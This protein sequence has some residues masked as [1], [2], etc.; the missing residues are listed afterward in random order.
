VIRKDSNLTVLLTNH[1]TPGHSIET[2]HIEV[3]LDNA[4]EPLDI[5]IQRI[6]SVHANPKAVW[7]DMGQPEYLTEQDVEQL[8][9]ASSLVKERQSFSNKDGAVVLELDLPRDAV[10]AITMEFPT[11]QK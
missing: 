10:A 8:Q 3:R 9:E 5:H 2:E 11:N 7:L 6:D 4:S 1:A